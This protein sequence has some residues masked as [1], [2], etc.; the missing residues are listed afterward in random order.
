MITS[1]DTIEKVFSVVF[2]TDEI[3]DKVCTE[4]NGL[5]FTHHHFDYY[6]DELLLIA[7]VDE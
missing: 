6:E 5:L 3:I 4:R 7:S 2:I 1:G